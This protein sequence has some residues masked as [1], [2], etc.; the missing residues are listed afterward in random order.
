[1]VA[2]NVLDR[3]HQHVKSAISSGRGKFSE[4]TRGAFDQLDNP[5]AGNPLSVWLDK[6]SDMTPGKLIDSVFGANSEDIGNWKSQF[7][8]Y[9]N[10]SAKLLT[11]VAGAEIGAYFGGQGGLVAGELIAALGDDAID[12]FSGKSD[13]EHHYKVGDWV[14]VDLGKKK[15][16][17]KKLK[18]QE[19]WAETM[20]FGDYDMTLHKDEEREDY[21]VGFYVGKSTLE[22]E[23]MVFVFERKKVD[24]VRHTRIRPMSQIQSDKYDS[25]FEYSLVR[26]IFL[27]KEENPHLIDHIKTVPCESG[28]EVIYKDKV[29]HV[30]VCTGLTAIIEDVTGD[31]QKVDMTQLSR[32]RTTNNTMY[33]YTKGEIDGENEV[34]SYHTPQS[35]V[36]GDFCWIPADKENQR[37]V[38][39][40][41]VVLCVVSY[42]QGQNAIVYECFNGR[43]R[44]LGTRFVQTPTGEIRDYLSQFPDFQKFRLEAAES[45][46]TVSHHAVGSRYVL[47]CHGVVEGFGVISYDDGTTTERGMKDTP[48]GQEIHGE[49]SHQ[50]QPSTHYLVQGSPNETGGSDPEG[51]QAI[52]NNVAMI[53]GGV[54]VVAIVFYVAKS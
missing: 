42:F 12:R 23:S 25:S 51:S 14:I 34:S 20:M 30:V 43:E 24:S 28:S 7:G 9:I 13:P 53:L 16:D 50:V 44:Q 48:K 45:S 39:S 17:S 52:G 22:T 33:N 31:R 35:L 21:S 26:E 36:S 10:H 2:Q 3:V 40:C 6:V 15:H 8:D 37:T 29:Y 49:I 54:A 27:E 18:R 38:P 11:R 4:M 5:D 32:G 19:M 1:M 46:T 47:V 41:E